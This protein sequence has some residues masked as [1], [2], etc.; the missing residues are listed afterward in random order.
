MMKK[1]S[2]L[3]SLKDISKTK[4]FP[5]IKKML[6]IQKKHEAKEEKKYSKGLDKAI[7]IQGFF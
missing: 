6:D 7:F 2:R 5:Q 1:I 4:V 3:G